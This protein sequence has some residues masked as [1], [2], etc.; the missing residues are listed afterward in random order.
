MNLRCAIDG[1]NRW[2]ES[3]VVACVSRFNFNS[4]EDVRIS[5]DWVDK[6]IS[7]SNESDTSFLGLVF[8]EPDSVQ[9]QITFE[10]LSGAAHQYLGQICDS[11]QSCICYSTGILALRKRRMIARKTIIENLNDLAYTYDVRCLSPFRDLW[12]Q[13]YCE[14]TN[15]TELDAQFDKLAARHLHLFYRQASSWIA[16]GGTT[17]QARMALR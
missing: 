14:T 13:F 3:H 16:S 10:C 7:K 1:I 9:A 5:I 12:L 6:V 4:S 8:N 11:E 15:P 2:P 17:G